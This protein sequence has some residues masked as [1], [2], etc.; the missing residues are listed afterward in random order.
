MYALSVPAHGQTCIPDPATVEVYATA[1]RFMSCPAGDGES[2]AHL[3]IEVYVII[4]E[5]PVEAFPYQDI[6]LDDYDPADPEGFT[7]CQGG[8]YADQS[9]DE[10]GYTTISG[11][12]AG[13][14]WVQS[15]MAVYIS[16]I[17]AGGGDGPIL[18]IDTNGPDLNGDRVVDL[19]DVGFFSADLLEPIA[20][21]RSDLVDAG[22]GPVDLADVGRLAAH[23]GH[24]CP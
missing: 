8:S 24:E 12:H 1:G 23:I 22:P 6:W 16:G 7:L 5:E 4:C 15:G 21:F 19:I 18:P 9:T 17:V 10:N 3:A 2:T 13:G 14:G 11:V 20:P